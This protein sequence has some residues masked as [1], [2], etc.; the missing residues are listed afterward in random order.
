MLSC[1]LVK[2]AE[3]VGGAGIAKQRVFISTTT[4]THEKEFPEFSAA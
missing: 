1:M 2:E 4:G 3:V